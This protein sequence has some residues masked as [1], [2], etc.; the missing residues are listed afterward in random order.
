M[1]ISYVTIRI[2]KYQRFWLFITIALILYPSPEKN[3]NA[4][5]FMLVII[6]SLVYISFFFFAL[7]RAFIKDPSVA[8]HTL[9]RTTHYFVYLHLRFSLSFYR[10]KKLSLSL[11]GSKRLP[12]RLV[13]YARHSFNFIAQS[14]NL[15]FLSYSSLRI[16]WMGFLNENE[17]EYKSWLSLLM[18]CA[19]QVCTFCSFKFWIIEPK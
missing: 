11:S 3:I 7:A 4:I 1:N 14:C 18:E 2:M 5:W 8:A 12:F 9:R 15:A 19:L 17:N 10:L 6:L 16:F 13:I